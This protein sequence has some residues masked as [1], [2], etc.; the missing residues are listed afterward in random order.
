MTS[1]VNRLNRAVLILLGLLLSIGAAAGLAL[2]AGAFGGPDSRRQLLEPHVSAYADRTP[3]FWWVVAAGSVVV[4]LLSLSW[5]LAQVRTD[6]IGRIDL[7]I[8]DAD[9]ATVVHVGAVAEAVEQEVGSFTG[10]TAASARLRGDRARRLDLIVVLS[11]AAELTQLRN[12]LQKQTVAN[13]R[14]VLNAPDLPVHV[15][16]RPTPKGRTRPL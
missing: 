8:D 3:W 6:R 13:L 14:R 9:G 11:Q 2:G 7:A 12:R 16:L 5:L 1:G 4:A 10:V 15:Q